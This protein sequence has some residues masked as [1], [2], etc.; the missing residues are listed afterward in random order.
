MIVFFLIA[1]EQFL[2]ILRPVRILLPMFP[3]ARRSFPFPDLKDAA[4]RNANFSVTRDLLPSP[5]D[6]CRHSAPQRCRCFRCHVLQR[7]RRKIKISSWFPLA[8]GQIVNIIARADMFNKAII[9]FKH[10][11][12]KIRKILFPPSMPRFVRERTKDCLIIPR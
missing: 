4:E 5:I 11:V 9:V 6:A 2:N 3:S 8:P 1:S 10:S 7:A 12:F